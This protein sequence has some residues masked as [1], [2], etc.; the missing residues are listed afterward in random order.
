VIGQT[1]SHYRI[2][3]RLGSGGMGVVY[4]AQDLTLGRRVALKFLPAEIADEP[5]ALDR[6]LLEARAASALNHPNICTIYAVESDAAQSF[7]SMELLE[8]QSLEAKLHTGPL[9]V[10][11]LLDIGTQLADALDAAHAK[12]IIHRDIKPANIFLTPRGQIKILDFGLAKLTRD[13]HL[14]TQATQT[15]SGPAFLTSP[16]SAVG[17]IAYMSPEQAR[18][19]ELDARSDI[20]SLGDVLYQM[21][22]GRVPFSGSTSALIFNA[23]LEKEPV[24]ILTIDPQL[25]ARLQEVVHR[26][27]E[28]DRELRYQT[29]ADLRGDLKRLKRDLESSRKVSA[30]VSA[31]T[32][33]EQ[34]P[35]SPRPSSD[36]PRPSPAGTTSRATTSTTTGTAA[37]NNRRAAVPA[38]VLLAL[39]AVAAYGIY[40]WLT[41]KPVVAFQNLSVTKQTET[42]KATRVAISPDGK[43]MLNAV[44]ANGQESLWLRNVPTNSNA[45]VIAM[46]PVHYTGLR[47]SPDGNYLFFIR[48]EAGSQELELLYRAPLLGGAPERLVSDIDSN[49]TFSP[50][51]R[52]FAF[53][54]NDDPEPGKYQLI[55]HTLGSGNDRVIAS[56]PVSSSLFFP[57]WSPD[58]T[59]IACV[60]L[61]PA[62]AITGLVAID[63]ATGKQ[64]LFYTASTGILGATAW[65]PDGKSLITLVRD[66]DSNFTRNQILFVPYP[67]GA[68]RLITRDI[69]DYSDLSLS[70]DG[71]LLATVLNETHWNIFMLPASPGGEKSMRQLTNG[72]PVSS[73]SWTPKGQLVFSQDMALF[74][75]DPASGARSAINLTGGGLATQPS[76]CADGKY[77]V[78]A[79]AGHAGAK[80]QNIWRMQPDSDDLKQLTDGKLE[81]FPVC[82]PDGQWVFFVDSSNGGKL[83]KV[84][85]EGGTPQKLTDVPVIG[86]FVFSPDGK[87]L[88]LMTLDHLGSHEEKLAL[89]DAASGATLKQLEFQRA[90]SGPVRFAPEGNA[91]VYPVREAD[92]ANLW[93]QPL[94][95]SPGKPITSFSSELIGNSFAWSFDKTKLAIIRGHV[96]SDVVLIRDSQ[97]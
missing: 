42:G 53:I 8:G 72:A 88:A 83:F 54:R 64:Q 4:E 70:A 24:P 92:T 91:V 31:T 52:Q 45:Q 21:A 19:E 93:R 97:P 39:V 12:G 86:D 27:L 79:L 59:K 46:A 13:A 87:T 50:D 11:L 60:I 82:A 44:A 3:S 63:V 66:Q 49:L 65:L 81:Q 95:G 80:R 20:F 77:L 23:I 14:A 35:T 6:F 51:G 75:L 22:T 37:Q 10:D 94:D 36:P 43:Y 41:P 40:A 32:L 85:L 2:L 28:K 89:I 38:L 15:G 68:S 67:Q 74:S 7:I 62:N 34:P 26:A 58:G 25:P 17:T 16:G 48:S 47:F 71:H 56:G 76:A 90:R 96:D 29:S 33:V 61:Q 9:P 30:S 69:N 57:A 84:P 18:G 5:A 1:I 73:F 78:F 55:V